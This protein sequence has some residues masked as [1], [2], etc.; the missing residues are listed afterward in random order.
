MAD[1]IS[2][3]DTDHPIYVND[4]HRQ[5]HARLLALGLGRYIEKSDDVVL[6]YGCGEALHAGRIA[7]ACGRLIL[8][9]AA[10]KLRASLAERFADNDRISV[11]SPQDVEAMPDASVDLVVLHSVAQYLTRDDLAGLLSLFRGL[12]RPSGRLVLGDIVRPDVSALTDAGALV[13]LAAANGFFFAAISGLA[14]TLLSDYWKLRQSTGLTRYGEK[15][16]LKM[17]DAAGLS[18]ARVRPNVGH[19]QARMTFLAHPR[20]DQA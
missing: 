13:G 9:E 3:F 5:V 7:E 14:R 18:G 15:Y 10:P 6:D 8:C 12:L 19:N 2:F 1:W 17:L 20:G 16:I 4:R 11:M